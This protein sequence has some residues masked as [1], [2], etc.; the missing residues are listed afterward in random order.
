MVADAHLDTQW[1]WDIL[2]TIKQYL[3]NTLDANFALF[4]K[5][6]NYKFNFEGAI[7]YMWFKEYYPEK[8]A[9]LKTYVASGQWNIAG[10]SLD[11]N[12]IIVPSPESQFRNIL[13]G[14]TF[15]KKE[16]GKK[17]ND[18]FLPD[19]FG[20]GYTLP[21]IMKHA[22]LIGFTTQKLSWGGVVTP[23]KF[24]T[25][26]GVDGS[27][28]LAAASAGD[29]GH[30]YDED[31]SNNAELI[32][33]ADETSTKT[34]GKYPIVYRLYGTGDRG[35]SP[36]DNSANSVE[37]G[38][39]GTG[40]VQIKSATS[41]QM[42]DDY[43]SKIN[44]F[45]LYNG[46]LIMTQHGTGCY[47]SRTMMK[48]L[49]RKNELLADA[50][51]RTAVIADW[52][53]GLKYPAIELN[54]AWI[55]FIWHQFHDDLTGTS[56]PSAYTFS[57]NDEMLAQNKFSS[58][59]TN[60]VGAGVR[61]LNTQVEGTAIV[62]YNPLSVDR[63]DVAEATI[64]V[65][66]KT[67]FVKVF[68]KAGAEVPAQV[69]ESTDTQV[70]IIFVASVKSVGYEVYDVRPSTT[71]PTA[72]ADLKITANSLENS[73][74]KV[75]LSSNGDI[76]SIIDKTNG[77]KQLLNAPIR[78]AMLNN[79]SDFWP[80]WE[81]TY[82]AVSA[83]PRAYVDGTPE[84]SIVEQG[85]VRVTLKITRKK[86]K[87]T[88]VQYVRLTN[89]DI[90][91]RIDVDNEVDWKSG[92]TLLKAV[93]PFT[94]SNSNA[95]YDLG[96]GVIKHPNN[97]SARYE[98]PGQQ[99]ADITSADNS[100]GVSI[101]NDCKY[102]WDKPTNNTLR[103]SL[104]HTPEVTTRYIY[105]GNQD[106]GSNKFTYSIYGHANTCLNAES[107]LEASKL[108]Q[109]LM[110]FEAPKHDGELGKAFSF[111]NVN[112]TQV[113]LKT[114][115]K[116]ENSNDYV[117]RFYE[118]K[119]TAANNVKVKFAS[120]I[121]AA[122]ELNAIE[123]EIGAAT[124]SDSTLTINMTAFQPKTFSVQL[125]APATALPLP[126]CQPLVLPYNWDAISLQA[127]MTN[128]NF[129][130]KT[131][132]YAA[133]LLPDTLISD[134]IKFKI[135]PTTAGRLNVLRCNANKIAIPAG[136]K[137]LY[138]LASS[139]N[140]AGTTA[141]F[142]MNT[143]TYSLN[144]PYFSGFMGQATMYNFVGGDTVLN[145]SYLKLDNVAWTGGHM[146]NGSSKTDQAYAFTYLYKYC[147]DIPE[148]TTELV[149]PVSNSIGIFAITVA[150][151][152]NDDTK[153][154]T[155]FREIQKSDSLVVKTFCG[156]NLSRSKIA[157]ASGQTNAN[158]SASMAFDGNETSTKWCQN[159]A[160]PK[161][162]AIDLGSPKTI[163]EWRVKHA[164]F[165]SENYITKDFSLQKFDGTSWVDVDVVT[166][167][168]LNTTD[169]L[170]TPFVAQKLRLYIT[171]S[172]RDNAARILEF[173]LF[174]DTYSAISEVKSSNIS[175]NVSPNP[176]KSG[177][178][179]LH[180]S[181]FYT[182]D[183]VIVT[184]NDVCGHEIYNSRI[185]YK[186]TIALNLDTKLRNGIY[187]VTVKNGN[188]S[189]NAKFIV[190]N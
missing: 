107:G 82:A 189:E 101:L 136:Y 167:N 163:C 75:A 7:K 66:S 11:A 179:N 46:E 92:K 149:L 57:H 87:S 23:F 124:F 58:V 143:K 37:R 138:I 132:S 160:G 176:V 114:L 63:T 106:L 42:F 70:K 83:T 183:D 148:G 117:V 84:I 33:W 168:I 45:P 76:S 61:K 4:K 71:A 52:L 128:G 67:D 144:V 165:E 28:V 29:Y 126:E 16:F 158:E 35:G 30:K 15:Y 74:Y 157:T 19:C 105:Q 6:P 17:S 80:S 102:G 32:S 8:Y 171:N 156:A 146:H 49:N 14:Q 185:E 24:G 129:D 79:L 47:T 100:Y 150:N 130:G 162:L 133:E 68:D 96:I 134:G 181:G 135:G 36:D 77:N 94:V 116:A 97:S 34:G 1:D 188:Q 113:V 147:L 172:G 120:K 40:P 99:W 38:I 115:K 18:I 103:L 59:L 139:I 54:D 89:T 187:F 104:I 86:E 166:G 180:L 93:F 177:L 164:G 56:V 5:Y 184:I 13:I 69:I 119:G 91:K 2:T 44:E 174:G 25:W 142:V 127:D 60:A 21:T 190:C 137:K 31:L 145:S 95:T 55:R 12:D 51:E 10:S 186:Q 43:I 90:K 121:V 111:V 123:E 65:A 169:R 122:K 182:N 140:A 155:E 62:V 153:P 41:G 118:T 125:E 141:N 170:V 27:K 112:T 131:N 108:N 152:Q 53:G 161:W 85:P 154:A 39:A 20:F 48:R 159:V 178:I 50:T 98:V 64:K 109:P 22:G 151:N 110:A 73:I 26:Q 175:L 9:Q 3:P 173:Q 81:V 78:L 72:D 88:F